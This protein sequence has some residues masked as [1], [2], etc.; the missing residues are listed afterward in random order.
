MM[1]GVLLRRVLVMFGGVQGMAVRDLGMMRCLLVIAGAMVFGGFAMMLGRM[2][3]MMR[4]FFVMF[5][6]LV[7]VHGWLPPLVES[8]HRC[9]Q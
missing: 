4:R 2:V 1:L 7:A 3:M 5:M 8:Q 9:G 6:D